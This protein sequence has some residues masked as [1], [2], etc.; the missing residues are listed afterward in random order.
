MPDQKDTPQP[1]E[2]VLGGGSSVPDTAGSA[3]GGSS[4]DAPAETETEAHPS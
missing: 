3:A 1:E 2:T 4:E